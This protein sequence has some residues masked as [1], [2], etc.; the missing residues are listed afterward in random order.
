MT[1][2]ALD[3][4]RGAHRLLPSAVKKRN[5]GKRR[6]ALTKPTDVQD[7]PRRRWGPAGV[8]GAGLVLAALI[9][10]SSLVF[11]RADKPILWPPSSNTI[12][13]V[14]YGVLGTIAMIAALLLVYL[15]VAV[16]AAWKGRDTW[17]GFRDRVITAVVT[18]AVVVTSL[19]VSLHVFYWP[20]ARASAVHTVLLNGEKWRLV[21]CAATIADHRDE[22]AA[23]A[24]EDALPGPSAPV[25]AAAAYALAATGDKENLRRLI[26]V[27]EDLPDKRP[28]GEPISRDNNVSSREDLVWLSKE[29]TDADAAT[30]DD[31]AR[32][33]SS[34]SRI[35]WDHQA[36]RFVTARTAK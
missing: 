6:I 34:Y 8:L 7:A 21:Q 33:V 5:C 15:A 27:A 13:E 18:L 9:M 11:F 4:L 17:K 22:A 10:L 36:G 14:V 12:V 25:R 2:F 19:A 3:A 28:D 35:S 20:W 32:W 1:P 29:L 30:F 31:L 26:T 23:K 24:L 16:L